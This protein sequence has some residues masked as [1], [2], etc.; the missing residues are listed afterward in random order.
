MGSPIDAAI[1][2]APIVVHLPSPSRCTRA[3]VL[4]A[5]AT[6]HCG[7]MDEYY[8]SRCVMPPKQAA[9]LLLSP[10][11]EEWLRFFSLPI[12]DGLVLATMIARFQLRPIVDRRLGPGVVVLGWHPIDG[13]CWRFEFDKDQESNHG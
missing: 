5:M 1:A 11:A 6:A 7:P 13:C 8:N 4:R 3:Q 10:S 2:A 9:H 12:S